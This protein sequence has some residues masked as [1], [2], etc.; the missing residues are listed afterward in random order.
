[1]FGFRDSITVIASFLH[2]SDVVAFL[3]TSKR[4]AV[5]VKSKVY[6]AGSSSIPP[7]GLKYFPLFRNI[8]TTTQAQN[9][10]T[11]SHCSGLD[12]LTVEGTFDL[13]SI[14]LVAETI[15]NN[16]HLTSLNLSS[17]TFGDDRR[18][19]YTTKSRPN[20]YI[21][22]LPYIIT[23]LP[24]SQSH[25][26][27][28]SDLHWPHVLDCTL[29]LFV[30]SFRS[31][32]NRQGVPPYPPEPEGKCVDGSPHDRRRS[33][34]SHS[35]FLGC[36]LMPQ[37]FWCWLEI[38]FSRL[39]A[40]QLAGCVSH[41]RHRQGRPGFGQMLATNIF[42]FLFVCWRDRRDHWSCY[43]QL[44]TAHISELGSLQ[45]VGCQCSSNRGQLSKSESS[46]C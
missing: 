43:T 16:H 1:M 3:Q 30:G 35:A 8:I 41:V 4:S 25:P 5:D 40:S 19:G 15:A 6:R 23:P 44:C 46:G 38:R 39:P 10:E 29:Q 24:F 7:R 2:I 26:R 27:S 22:D 33:L 17:A 28:D 31:G 9:L 34:L 42:V 12:A 20:A 32:I 37:S 36:Q 14:P 13:D 18:K 11:V 45:H 21:S